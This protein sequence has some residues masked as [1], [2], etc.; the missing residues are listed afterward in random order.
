MADEQKPSDEQ[1]PP[2]L[3]LTK[4]GEGGTPGDEKGETMQ[5]RVPPGSEAP[6]LK[7]RPATKKQGPATQ[8]A[9][10]ETAR[11]PLEEATTEPSDGKGKPSGAP[12]TI[13]IK[14]IT[15]K[16]AAIPPPVASE[17]AS[18]DDKRKTSRISLDA[19]FAET[20]KDEGEG[21]PEKPKTIR[22]KRPTEAATI[23]IARRPTPPTAPSPEAVTPS[24]AKT[25]LSKTSRIDNLP[26]A[27]E[28]ITPTRRKTIRVKRPTTSQPVKSLSIKRT[29][30]EAG[31]G[32]EFVP[33]EP[34]P[35]PDEPNF[36]FPIFAVAAM[37]IVCVT[38]Y[39]LCAQAFGPN[40]SLTQLSWWPSGPNLAWPDKI[41]LIPW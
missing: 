5:I 3:D 18:L 32:L 17:P 38:I 8:K 6:T 29:D 9:K 20:D 23:K 12:K 24:E 28:E 7:I 10:K 41:P 21:A 13:R 19:V 34:P 25:V 35:P 40:A 39:V 31:E 15:K 27:E 16:K 37:L 36:L 22:L 33:E 4:N 2:K 30:E 11:I 26:E 14:P 1:I